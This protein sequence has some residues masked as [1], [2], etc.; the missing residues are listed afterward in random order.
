M[1]LANSAAGAAPSRC[2]A[3]R[4]NGA[5]SIWQRH[6]H[7]LHGV[8]PE[9]ADVEGLVRL[10]LP[11]KLTAL[12]HLQLKKVLSL[13]HLSPLPQRTHTDR[14]RPLIAPSLNASG[15]SDACVGRTNNH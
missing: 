9:N 6:C 14:H 4:V 8:W 7:A 3:V 11:F 10:L 13:G 5:P 12:K 15:S 1:S 2:T